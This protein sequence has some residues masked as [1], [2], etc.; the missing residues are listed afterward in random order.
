M[1]ADGW[2]WL[3]TE[4]MTVAVLVRDT[5]VVTAPP[6]VRK[7][8]G[9]PALNLIRWLARQPGFASSYIGAE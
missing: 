4:R 7:F 8:V 3:T 9:Q 5:V 2:Y 1:S 6:I